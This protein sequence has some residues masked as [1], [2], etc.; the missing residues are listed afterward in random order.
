MDTSANARRS[1]LASWNEAAFCT[2]RIASRRTS[3]LKSSTPSPSRSSRGKKREPTDLAVPLLPLEADHADPRA[4]RA[5]EAWL[6]LN[7]PGTGGPRAAGA[8]DGRRVARAGPGVV[9]EL[10]LQ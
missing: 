8:G 6:V 1:S 10:L 4:Q 9:S 2:C 7:G 5:L 3:G